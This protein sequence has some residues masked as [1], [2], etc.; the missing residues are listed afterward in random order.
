MNDGVIFDAGSISLLP[1]VLAESVWA[2]Q[3]GLLKRERTRL[4]LVQAAIRVFSARG[5]ADAT[6]QEIATAASMT[7]GTVYNHFKTKEEVASA[8]ALLLAH[9]LCRRI[10]DSQQGVAEGAQR[11]A[12][13][14]RRYIWLAEQ[15]PEWARMMLDV[16]AAAPE[17]LLEL[18][19]Y[20]LADLRLG[21]KQ[22]AFRVPSEM[23]AMDLINGTVQQA[24]RTVALGGAPGSHGREVAS[25]VLRGLGMEWAEAKRTAQRALPPFPP[26]SGGP[27]AQANTVVAPAKKAKR[28]AP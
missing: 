9:T 6:M 8:V 1:G 26:M 19:D 2:P 10:T 13:G 22:K 12:I 27:A 4:Q 15:S 11:M 18:R 28:A 20:V 3:P 14:I 17:M 24:M 16:S 23:A 25:G 5:Y 7:T 21:M